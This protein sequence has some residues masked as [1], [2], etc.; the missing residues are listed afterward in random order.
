MHRVTLIE[1]DGIGPEVVRAACGVLDAA[2]ADIEWEPAEIG[3]TALDRTGHSVPVGTLDSLKRN[4][5][6]LKGP[7]TTPIGQG[8][9]SVNVQLRKELGLF[10][11]VRPIKSLP[12]VS[13]LYSNVDLTIIR[14]NTED[15]YCGIEHEVIPGVIEAIK[16]I[17][18]EASLR[19]A[20]FAFNY[21][22][23][24][25]YQSVTAIHKAN[26][27]KLSDGL[28]LDCC[29][30][31]ALEFPNLIL[32]EKIV[33]NAAMRLVMRPQEFGVLVAPNLYGDIISDL[34]A[35]LV[36][37]LGLVPGANIGKDCAVFEAVHGSWPEAA[38]QG[39]ANPTAMIL[40]ASLL[41]RHLGEVK[42]ATAIET[43]VLQTLAQGTILT[44]DLG[45][46][47]STDEFAS[48]VIKRL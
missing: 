11:C 36:G 45:G 20:R 3:L 37:G 39:I 6:G 40:T 30:Q 7:A 48:S 8:I 17:T 18:R 31:A 33:D 41:L 42:K 32:D 38:G 15:L 22:E 21:A 25:G 24:F 14:E 1:G 29:R 19:I 9:T 4:R 10:A 47:A 2:G 23:R 44:P 28:F 16:L 13:S 43:A 46:T 26:I 27:L 35:G 5:V 12:G 34:A